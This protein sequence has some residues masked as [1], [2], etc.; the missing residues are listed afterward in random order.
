MPFDIPEVEVVNMSKNQP[1]KL[2][3]E[4]GDYVYEPYNPQTIYRVVAIEGPHTPDMDLGWDVRI[5]DADGNQKVKWD[6]HVN[7]FNDLLASTR[8]KVK[9]HETTLAK[10]EQ[11]N[12]K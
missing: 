4:V 5:E 12:P 2:R 1:R 9:T 8:K 6:N 3:H 7:N 11:K 10:F